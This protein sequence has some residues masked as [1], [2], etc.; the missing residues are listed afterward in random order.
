[1]AKFVIH[2]RGFFYTD[3]AFELAEGE[4]GSIVGTFNNLDEAKIEKLKQDIISI[5]YFG[6]MNVVDFFFYNDNYDEIYE[7]F[8]VFFRSEF[9]LEIE[10]K[11]CFD[12]PDAISFEQAEKI[13]EILNITFHDIVEYDDD[14]VLN[15][16][17]FN[18]E[19]SELGEF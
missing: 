15:P 13:Y 19:E 3:E 2:K 9:N 8:E 1:M 18:L 7:K 10:D 14:V 6:G 16:D 5:E 17:D 11:Y 4:L 12:F